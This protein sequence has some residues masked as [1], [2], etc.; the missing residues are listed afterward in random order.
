MNVQH[1]RPEDPLML[2]YPTSN[3]LSY[4]ICQ[5]QYVTSVSGM[6]GLRADAAAACL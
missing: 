3:Q 5:I 1:D 4:C 2:R 6:T